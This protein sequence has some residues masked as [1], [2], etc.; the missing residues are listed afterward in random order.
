MGEA[1]QN[2]VTTG[3]AGRDAATAELKKL[4][5]A[6]EKGQLDAKKLE[7]Q[8]SQIQTSLD[9]SNARLFES[10][11]AVRQEKV[12]TA[13]LLAFNIRAVGASIFANSL[14]LA[15]LRAQAGKDAD[16]QKQLDQ[17]RARIGEYD[18][19]LTKS[20]G[21][22]IQI[23]LDLAAASP[24]DLDKAS[25]GVKREFTAEGMQ[26]FDTYRQQALRHVQRA[27]ELNRQ[28]SQAEQQKWLY[29]V[30]ATRELREQRLKDLK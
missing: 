8:L 26:L 29:E 20:F 25:D 5:D 2:I 27:T 14:I 9:A 6:N 13:T 4:R 21:F 28:I 15:E 22:Y 23:I 30:D 19:S 11:R 24:A 17:V 10:A 12:E 7:A 16:K 18:R 1:L 3:D